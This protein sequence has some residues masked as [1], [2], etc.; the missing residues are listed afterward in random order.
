MMLL[1]CPWCGPRPETEF[2]CGGTT[3]I[4]RPPLDCSDETWGRYLFFRANP[5]GAHHER[6]RHGYGCGMWFNLMRDTVTHELG[7]TSHM[8]EA[9]AAEADHAVAT[10]VA[11]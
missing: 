8:N 10:A 2:H 5:K 7:A 4:V 6:W 9:G 11:P 1:H 3:A